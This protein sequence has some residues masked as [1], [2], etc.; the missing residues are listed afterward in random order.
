M[1]RTSGGCASKSRKGLEG[2]L[3]DLET[4]IIQQQVVIPQFQAGHV[5]SG[6]LLGTRAI[7]QSDSRRVQSA[8]QPAGTH[9][10]KGSPWPMAII[11]VILI[12][13]FI[14]RFP[15]AGMLLLFSGMLAR[16]GGG[17][18]GGG[19]G[20]SGGGGSF[21]GGGSSSSW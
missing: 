7:V 12:I 16:G 2:A 11:I 13:L 17:G 15:R 21:G 20:F 19:G 18:G 8:P 3:T 9:D 4:Q 1:P 10:I 14:F 6:V 5:D